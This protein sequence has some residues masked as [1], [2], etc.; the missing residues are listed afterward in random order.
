MAKRGIVIDLGPHAVTVYDPA[1]KGGPRTLVLP[2]EGDGLHTESAVFGAWL[3][4]QLREHRVSAG[5]VV[6]A[7]RRSRVVLKVVDL[8]PAGSIRPAELGGM[9]RLQLERRSHVPLEGASVDHARLAPIA[10][11]GE[12][13][14]TEHAVLAAFPADD[15]A[16]FDDVAKQIKRPLGGLRLRAD[17]AAQAAGNAGPCLVV[18]L[19]PGGAELVIA[20]AARTVVAR[21]VDAPGDDAA[22]RIAVE[23]KRLVMAAKGGE[24]HAPAPESVVVMGPNAGTDAVRNA[25]AEALGLPVETL[26][27]DDEAGYSIALAP[28]AEQPGVRAGERIDFANPAKAPDTNARPRQLVLASLLLIALLGGGGY[29][30]ADRALG[31][32]R[33]AKTRIESEENTARGEYARTVRAELRLKHIEAWLSADVDWLAHIEHVSGSVPGPERALVDGLSVTYEAPVG[34]KPGDSVLSG[35]FPAPIS[36]VLRVEGRSRDRDVSLA[37][38]QHLLEAQSYSVISRGPDVDDRFSLELRTAQPAPPAS[39]GQVTASRDGGG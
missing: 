15:R 9:L 12:T 31:D 3:A 19:G 7:V 30:L 4:A 11:E 25:C 20:H 33:A 38:R 8:P 23:C 24:A 37:M 14:D 27:E 17:G 22:E 21:T 36:A 6:F 18:A 35:S 28:L 32:L 2:R 26:S 13:S 16:W 5:A 10:H 34:Y 39:S 1:A 29:V